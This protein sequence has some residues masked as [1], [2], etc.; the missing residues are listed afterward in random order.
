MDK[1]KLIGTII[2]VIMFAA[3]IA[4]ATFAWLTFTANVYNATYVSNTMNFLVDYTKGTAIVDIPI[5]KEGVPGVGGENDGSSYLIVKAKKHSGSPDGYVTIQLTTS[6]STTLTTG[7]IINWAICKGAC[8]TNFTAA[9]ATGTIT[10]KG[11]IDLWTDDTVLQT[12]DVS[13]YVYFWIDASKLENSHLN[14]TY[15]GYIHAYAEQ[16]ET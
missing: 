13:Y 14:Q 8:T 3:L 11:T 2:G 7:G 4:G 1:K 5:V 12:S 9:K 16:K 10:E 6:S 15:Q